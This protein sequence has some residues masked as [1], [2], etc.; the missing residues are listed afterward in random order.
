MEALILE[1]RDIALY[2]SLLEGVEEDYYPHTGDYWLETYAAE[3]REG[4]ASYF[5]RDKYGFDSKINVDRDTLAFYSVPYEPGWTAT[6]NGEPVDIV[7]ANVGFM[8]VPVK[9]GENV[10]RFDFMTP[11]LKL[12]GL[13]SLASLLLI[14]LYAYILPGIYKK[15]TGEVLLDSDILADED[16]LSDALEEPMLEDEKMLGEQPEDF[17]RDS[18]FLKDE[19]TSQD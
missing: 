2:G 11:G 9:A 19:K 15:K 3:R 10:I 6:V 18:E 5:A 12:G 13:V 7:K 4:S 1:E 14:L 17:D 8:A 16:I